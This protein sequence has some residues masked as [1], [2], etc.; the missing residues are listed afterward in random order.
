VVVHGIASPGGAVSVNGQPARVDGEGRFAVEVSLPEGTH[1]ISVSAVDTLGNL[2]TRVIRIT[3][4]APQP[5][6]LFV[7]EPKDQ[8]VVSSRNIRLSGKTGLGALVSINGVSIGVDAQGA[9][10]TTVTLEPGPNIIDVVS[11]SSDGQVLGA[12]LAIIYRA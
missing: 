10:T 7:I 3:F 2:L 12:V 1:Q 8:I 9:F 4:E 6:F 5:F 11:T